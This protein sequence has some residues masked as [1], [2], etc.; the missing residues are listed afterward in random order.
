MYT[1]LLL[2]VH[3]F[4]HDVAPSKYQPGVQVRGKPVTKSHVNSLVPHTVEQE[5]P[6]RSALHA[7]A[8]PVVLSHCEIVADVQAA[9]THT[10]HSNS[11]YYYARHCAA[12]NRIPNPSESQP[13]PK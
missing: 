4:E 13:Q 5:V 2:P 3:A 8:A 11:H 10:R 1:A 12:V 7:V 6:Q 9:H